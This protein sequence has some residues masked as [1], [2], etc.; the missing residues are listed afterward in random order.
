MALGK[1]AKGLCVVSLSLFYEI[2][3]AVGQRVTSELPKFE[4]R[5]GRI[6]SHRHQNAY[7]VGIDLQ[8]FPMKPSS[9]LI[10]STTT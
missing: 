7:P 6:Q 2:G 9:E 4:P 1:R 10:A 5:L 8:Y 3:V